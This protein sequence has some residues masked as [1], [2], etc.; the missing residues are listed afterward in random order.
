MI[1]L[2]ALA[3]ALLLAVIPAATAAERNPER[4]AI[5]PQST[6]ALLILKAEMLAPAPGQNVAYRVGLQRY[7]AAQQRMR[8]GPFGGHATFEARR[9][10]FVDGYLLL[11]VEPDTWVFRDLSRQRLWALCFNDGS[12]QFTVRPGEVVYLGEMDVR[13]HLDELMQKAITSGRTSTSNSRAV[14]FF[15]GI[16]PPLLKPVDEAGLAAVTAMVRARMPLTTSVPRAAEFAPARFGTG[17]DLFGLSRMC[18]G[19]W[20]GSAD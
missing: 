5:T 3:L 18:G 11:E 19:Y 20:T 8:G 12:L 17:R 1:M 14:H 15:D 16:T 10:N 4:I 2:R 7:D 9:R 6:T 13:S